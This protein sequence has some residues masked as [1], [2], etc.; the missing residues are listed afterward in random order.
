MF[1]KREYRLGGHRPAAVQRVLLAFAIACFT[2]S[3]LGVQW[4]GDG[5]FVYAYL[6]AFTFY[7]TIS[8]GALFF[9]MLHHLSGARWSI[10]LRRI[11]ETL[12]MN[13]PL[14]LVLFLPILFWLP[15]L[16]EWAPHSKFA[17]APEILKKSAFLNPTFFTIRAAIYF[18]V[19]IG[20]AALM[21]RR[22][23]RQD[24]TGEPALAESLRRWSAPG[25]LLFALTLTFA[26][27]DWIMSLDA[28][29]YSTI[30][31]VYIFSGAAVAIMAVLILIAIALGGSDALRG[32]HLERA[33]SRPG[34]IPFR[35]RHL[36][37]VHRLLANDADLDGQYP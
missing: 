26:S 28:R 37:G 31:G 17:P 11:A 3:L 19:W 24:V 10:V 20:L 33:L 27:F 32:A 6:V 34:Q 2:I 1:L 9:V 29:W 7:L 25:M 22:S 13:L 12:A 4:S 35:L 15:R 5:Q 21:Y 8:L 23:L 18:V 16:Y 36:L 14:M 30:F